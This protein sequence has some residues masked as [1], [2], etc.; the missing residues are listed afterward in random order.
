M[1][2]DLSTDLII[3]ILSKASKKMKAELSFTG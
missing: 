1:G 2:I 3:D